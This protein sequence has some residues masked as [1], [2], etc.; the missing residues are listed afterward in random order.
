MN[1][2]GRARSTLT[3]AGLL[4]G[5]VVV[6]V[7]RAQRDIDVARGQVRDERARRIDAEETAEQR[8]RDL[9]GALEALHAKTNEPDAETETS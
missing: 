3:W 4:I 7:D 6:L 9:D 5:M 2:L 1:E 8:Q